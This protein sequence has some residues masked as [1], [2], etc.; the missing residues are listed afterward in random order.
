VSS[1]AAPP[2]TPAPSYVGRTTLTPADGAV[3][4]KASTAQFG[5]FNSARVARYF[6]LVS[7]LAAVFCIEGYDVAP[8]VM[9]A[10][11][12]VLY[13]ITVVLAL[14]GA[15]LVGERYGYGQEREIVVDGDGMTIREPGMTVQYTWSRFRR[16]TETADHLMLFAGA[17]TI[18]VPKRAFAP[19]AFARVREL[20]AAHVRTGA[21]V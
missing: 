15:R 14:R 2:G 19:D 13:A 21:R 5:F 9:L 6:G 8:K 16:T 3:L 12:I 1:D 4:V 11:A 7:F 17:G 10:L 18:V 20:V